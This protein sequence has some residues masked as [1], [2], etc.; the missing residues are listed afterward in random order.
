MPGTGKVLNKVIAE[1]EANKEHMLLRL[2]VKDPNCHRFQNKIC[3]A[4]RRNPKDSN[5]REKSRPNVPEFKQESYCDMFGDLLGDD[6]PSR[7][8]VYWQQSNGSQQFPNFGLEQISFNLKSIQTQKVKFQT[9][10]V[11]YRN[12]CLQVEYNETYSEQI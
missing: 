1:K 8:L 7:K 5:K 11:Y 6:S 12:R 3:I 4:K 2:P 9:N 10:K